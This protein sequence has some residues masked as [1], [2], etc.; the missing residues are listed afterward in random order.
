MYVP[1]AAANM[2]DDDDDETVGGNLVIE[3]IA[4]VD[5]WQCGDDCN[6]VKKGELLDTFKRED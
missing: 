3:N 2:H 5:P 6:D 4:S 1:A